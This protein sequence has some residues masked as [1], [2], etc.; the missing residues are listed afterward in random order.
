MNTSLAAFFDGPGTPFQLRDVPLP[1]LEPG[2]I[3]RGLFAA[4]FAEAICTR[5]PDAARSRHLVSSVTK[6]WRKYTTCEGPIFA[7]SAAPHWIVET[8][9]CGESF[10]HAKHALRVGKDCPKSANTVENLAI[11]STTRN[12]DC[13]AAWRNSV[14][15]LP[16]HRSSRSTRYLRITRFVPRAV[17]RPPW[18]PQSARRVHSLAGES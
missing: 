1:I 15:C 12:G 10:A 5:H 7:I 14:I 4:P 16:T 18:R 3:L 2:E 11:R 8:A 9:L 17:A 6:S 13:A